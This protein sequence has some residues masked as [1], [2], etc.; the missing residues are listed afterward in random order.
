[1]EITVMK[2]PNCSG[3]INYDPH[4]RVVKCPYCDST[5][6]MDTEGRIAEEE[7]RRERMHNADMQAE[8]EKYLKD[9]KKWHLK[10]KIYYGVIAV[11]TCAAYLAD[12]FIKDGVGT[13]IVAILLIVMIGF[14]IWLNSVV[15][16]AP[17]AVE[18]GFKLKRGVGNTVKL[19]IMSILSSMGGLLIAVI[20][21]DI[22]N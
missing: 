2:C 6:N 16:N 19:Y 4:Q 11:A 17:A 13:A 7:L 5:L 12:K 8:R 1:M 9:V 3:D 22:I 21:E 10:K 14:P 15:P 20:V 18:S